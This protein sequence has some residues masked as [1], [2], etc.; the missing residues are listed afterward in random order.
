MSYL[1]QIHQPGDVKALSDKELQIL[2][3]EIREFLVSTVSRTGGHLAPNLGV[4]ELTLALHTVLNS[5]VDKII[6]DVGHQAYVHKLITG[7]REQFG[8]LRQLNGIS[9]FPKREE[10]PHDVFDTGHSST[11]ISAALGLAVARDLAGEDYEVVAVI[12]DGALSGGMAYEGLNH[13]GHVG[14]HFIVVLNDNEMSIAQNVGAMASYLSRLRTD[15]KYFRRKEELESFLRRLPNIGPRVV[16]LAG[17]IK[18]SFKYLV[19]PG[20]IFEELGFTYLGPIDGHN[21]TAMQEVF[22]R[23]KRTPGPVLV[24]VLTRKGKGYEPAEANPDLFHGIGPFEVTSG[25]PLGPPAGVPNYTQVF[26]RALARLAEADSRVVAITAAMP[27]GTGLKEFSQRF[28][29]RFFDVGIAEEHAVTLA[30]G[31]ATQGLRPVVAIYSTFLQRAFDQ[32]LHDICLQRL[33]VTL[34]IDRAGIVGDD[35][36]THQGLFDL[37]YLRCIPNMTVMVPRDEDRLQHMLAAALQNEVPAAIRYPRGQGA[38]VPLAETPRPVPWGQAELLLEGEDITIV[39]VGPL[40]Y[41]ALEAA[42]RLRAEGIRA[43]VIDA[44]FVKPLD[45]ELLLS[46]AAKTGRV[47][48][49]EE[50]VLAGGFGSAVLELLAQNGLAIPVNCLGVPDVFVRHGKPESLRQQLGLSPEGIAAR[51]RALLVTEREQRVI[52]ARPGRTGTRV[53]GHARASG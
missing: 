24:H 27:D 22:A 31:M 36:E 23:S 21:I 35:G 42:A 26:G 30:A 50:N 18:D 11:S 2:A 44:C 51:V 9:G 33:P 4:V 37:T 7:R 53:A 25:Q 41:A 46:W 38:G 34:A 43:A 13:A 14:T 39:A 47:L 1:E 15:P 29:R 28:P 19:L 48:T 40:V 8:R 17:R 32:V 10:S 3:G 49:V 20:V 16:H 6:W 5:P 45:Q 52:A 12:G